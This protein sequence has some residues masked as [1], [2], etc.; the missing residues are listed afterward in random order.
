MLSI[1]TL[2]HPEAVA[3]RKAKEEQEMRR[4]TTYLGQSAAETQSTQF[5]PSIS[6]N[7]HTYTDHMTEVK[8]WYYGDPLK[9]EGPSSV[10]QAYDP[11]NPWGLHNV[12]LITCIGRWIDSRRRRTLS[13]Q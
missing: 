6:F 3:E 4:L 1:F 11:C 8:P 2:Q 7:T 13:Q 12:N 9:A 10:Q 5:L